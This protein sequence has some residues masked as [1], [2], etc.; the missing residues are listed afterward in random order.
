S[1][2]VQPS[3]AGILCRIDQ[4]DPRDPIRNL[5][6]W[7]PGFRAARSPFHPQFVDRLRPFRVIR[8]MDW[9]ATNNSPVS[10]W[11]DRT[12]P[13]TAQ[14]AG[15]QGVA[16]E[17]MIDLCNELGADPWFCMPHRADDEYVRQFAELVRDRL[18]PAA[19][20]YVEWSN[21]AWNGIFQQAAWVQTEAKQR[22]QRWTWV[23]ADEARRDWDIWRAVLRDGT[24]D[25][26]KSDPAQRLRRVVAGQHYNPWVCQDIAERLDGQFDVIACG[27]YFFPQPADTASFNDS[28]PL[29]AVAASCRQNIDGPGIENWQKHQRLAAE[30]SKRLGR[31][32]ELAAYEGGQH[33]TTDGQTLAYTELFHRLQLDAAMKPLYQQLF[34]ALAACQFDLFVAYNYVGH[35]DA[36]GSWG[37]LRFQDE[38]A[39]EAPKFEA[40]LEAAAKVPQP[41][42]ASHP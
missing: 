4:S 6:V 11:S 17:Y 34:D 15:A 28:T 32:I 36:Y 37:H 3:N 27:A 21:E 9:A 25:D 39:A 2:A 35:H 26:R 18:D 29:A 19:R 5:Q 41:S 16:I 23:I 20:I 8:F 14:Q 7:M 22:Q 12:T 10:R 1:L 13:A 31:D 40:L 42:A 30:W 33:L 24:S 38:P